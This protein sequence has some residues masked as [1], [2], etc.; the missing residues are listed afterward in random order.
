MAG[1]A[2]VGSRRRLDSKFSSAVVLVVKWERNWWVVSDWDLGFGVG[3]GEEVVVEEL[4]GETLRP[5]LPGNDC[6]IDRTE[7]MVPELF[8]LRRL[9][10][11]GVEVK[12]QGDGVGD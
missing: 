5:E 10:F 1:A 11:V 3:F 7:R 9:D 6:G 2:V 4:E 12:E 8:I